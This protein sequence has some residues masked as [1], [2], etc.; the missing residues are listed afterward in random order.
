MAVNTINPFLLEAA[1]E[2]WKRIN[3]APQGHHVEPRKSHFGPQKQHN[4]PQKPH[5]EMKK[6]ITQELLSLRK[7]EEINKN[8]PKKHHYRTRSNFKMPDSCEKKVTFAVE[9]VQSGNQ[10]HH[11]QPIQPKHHEQPVQPKQPKEPKEKPVSKAFC[12]RCKLDHEKSEIVILLETIT[13]GEDKTYALCKKCSSKTEFFSPENDQLELLS[14]LSIH[15][16]NKNYVD[17]VILYLACCLKV[18][19]LSLDFNDSKSIKKAENMFPH[20]ILL[21][22]KRPSF[23]A[24]EFLANPFE[25]DLK[26]YP[27]EL[28]EERVKNFYKRFLRIHREH[29]EVHR[30]DC[31]VRK[32]Y[33]DC[34]VKIDTKGVSD[35]LFRRS[36]IVDD[37]YYM[38]FK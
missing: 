6:T 15:V 18:N 13:E 8:T 11:E 17:E 28:R 21:Y 19:F 30:E 5:F 4:G 25:I 29:C 2:E 31:E 10:K 33:C 14:G 38:S 1:A 32:E 36:R 20:S 37:D 12:S 24:V 9:T 27:E 34:V 22:G 23:L 16:I 26:A 3:N 7:I 35:Y